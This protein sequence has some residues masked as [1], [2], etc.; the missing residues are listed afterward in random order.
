MI[1]PDSI[2]E[3]FAS[4]ATQFPEAKCAAVDPDLFFPHAT[5]TYI[6]RRAKQ[7]CCTCPHMNECLQHALDND[8]RHGIWGGLDES[9]RAKLQRNISSPTNCKRG[10]LLTDSNSTMT[11]RGRARCKKCHREQRAASRQRRAAS[12]TTAKESA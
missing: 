12:T 10:H 9:E 2:T 6:A 8:E 4:T 11:S 1:S 5:E 7:V 3:L